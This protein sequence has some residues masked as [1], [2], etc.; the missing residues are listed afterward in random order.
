MMIESLESRQLY[1][2]S[3][4][5]PT[6]DQETQPVQPTVEQPVADCKYGQVTLGMRKSAGTTTGAF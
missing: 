5:T 1:S 2:V 4:P 3:V 6:P